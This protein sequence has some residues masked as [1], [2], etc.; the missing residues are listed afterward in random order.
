M[1]KSNIGIRNPE[2]SPADD[3]KKISKKLFEIKNN[4]LIKYALSIA[5]QVHSFLPPN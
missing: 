5:K 4:H 3:M 2:S 1:V